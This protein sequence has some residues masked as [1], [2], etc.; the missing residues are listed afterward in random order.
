MKPRPIYVPC[1]E[2]DSQIF[3]IFLKSCSFILKSEKIDYFQKFPKKNRI[4]SKKIGF[5]P[6]KSDIFQFSVMNVPFSTH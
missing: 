2:N 3:L 5:F 1:S 6:K 4:F